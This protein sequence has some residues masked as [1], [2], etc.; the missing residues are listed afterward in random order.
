LYGGENWTLWKI[1]QK[2]LA[3]YETYCRRRMVKISWTDHVIN[4]E[5]L[6]RVKEERNF[7][8]IIE[9]RKAN[10]M[11]ISWVGTSF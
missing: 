1:D 2:Y 3:I 5:V 4:E 11:V 10:W 8:R 6:H 7:L 9:R